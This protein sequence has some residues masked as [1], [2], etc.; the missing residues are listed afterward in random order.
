MQA[1][2]CR[3]WPLEGPGWEPGLEVSVLS[4]EPLRGRAGV[5]PS[6][7]G[8]GQ[9]RLPFAGRPSRLPG[10]RQL[11]SRGTACGALG[12]GPR[13]GRKH[14]G[15]RHLRRHVPAG[16]GGSGAV[17]LPGNRRLGPRGAP[18]PAAW[19]WAAGQRGALAGESRGT[20]PAC[21][22]VR[23]RAPEPGSRCL[24]GSRLFPCRSPPVF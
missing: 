20:A 15:L 13:R 3:L 5:T 16:A 21:V 14:A 10:A 6:A 2:W 23:M 7:G 22:S 1:G 4:A 8:A 17:P 18:A 12:P 11:P 19:I 24:V 9:P